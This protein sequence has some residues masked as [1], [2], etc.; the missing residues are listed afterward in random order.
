MAPDPREAATTELR[1]QT[2]DQDDATVIEC[3]GRLTLE[4]TEALK[5]LGKSVIP[6]SKR[7]V[8]DLKEVTRMDSA[9]LGAVVGLYISARR[10]KC[11]FQ[12]VNYNNSIRTLLGMTNLLSVFETCAQSGMRFP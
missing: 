6:Q 12:L 5:S 7:L 11:D 3:A 4:N 1:L 2:H 8:V 9:G 10:A